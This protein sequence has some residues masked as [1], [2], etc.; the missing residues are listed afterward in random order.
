MNVH[1]WPKADIPS[2]MGRG[3][4]SAQSHPAKAFRMATTTADQVSTGDQS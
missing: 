2:C 3:I 4:S 1:F